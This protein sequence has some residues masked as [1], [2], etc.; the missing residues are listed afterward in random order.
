MTLTL[1]QTEQEL[2]DAHNL[3]DGR[4][5]WRRNIIVDK[6]GGD[7]DKFKQE[8]PSDPDEAFLATGRPVF[9]AAQT[10]RM[11]DACV[12]P[13]ERGS[14]VAKVGGSD[15]KSNVTGFTPDEFGDLLIYQWPQPDCVYA[16]GADTAE[17]LD[18]DESNDPDAHSATVIDV[19]AKVAVAKL[20]GHSDTD[21]FGD[22]LG[23]LGW[24]YRCAL[25]G[26]EINNTSGGEVRQRLKAMNYPNIF[27]KQKYEKQGPEH[28]EILG[29]RTDKI[30]RE[31]MI[32]DLVM[33]VRE[34][35]ITVFDIETVK[36]M[37]RFI[38]DKTGKPTH[39][40]GEH[41]D[42]VI[43]LAIALQ[44]AISAAGN[45]TLEGYATVL[46]KAPSDRVH[47]ENY[48]NALAKNDAV[49]NMVDMEEVDEGWGL[50]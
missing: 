25:I 40:P 19:K 48:A 45:T 42:D 3:N 34:E 20:A 41:D 5:L 29:W 13:I 31:I 11:A 6:C 12:M 26:S 46:A 23:L 32:S 10:K 7:E 47:P 2:V 16:I 18:P 22:Q 38:R 30:S 44:M 17:G 4:L 9:P 8:Y 24:F 50:G 33:A 39:R 28:T 37:R 49:D 1:T 36:Q 43:G 14:I 21:I 15:L 35:W 27:R